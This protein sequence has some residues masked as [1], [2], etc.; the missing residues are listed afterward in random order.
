MDMFYNRILKICSQCEFSDPDEQLI[1]AIF[2]MSTVKA[3]DKL[4]NVPKTQLA[5]VPYCM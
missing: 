2:G 5:T 1:D 4:L 3:Q